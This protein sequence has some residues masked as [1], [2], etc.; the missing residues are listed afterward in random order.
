MPLYILSQ[1][2]LEFDEIIT[3]HLYRQFML[4]IL[5]DQI[6]TTACHPVVVSFDHCFS[7]PPLAP[8]H[9]CPS[10]CLLKVHDVPATI[11]A[12]IELH[13]SILSHLPAIDMAA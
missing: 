3:Q 11:P 2:I 1:Q 12:S 5:L 8:Y 9:L 13:T 4:L 6:Q 10:L 7:S